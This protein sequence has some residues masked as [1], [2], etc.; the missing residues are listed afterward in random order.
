MVVI[1]KEELLQAANESLDQLQLTASPGSP[2]DDACLTRNASK[3]K[4]G[5]TLKLSEAVWI[6]PNGMPP[7]DLAPM[8]RA[9]TSPKIALIRSVEAMRKSIIFA[10]L[11]C[12]GAPEIQPLGDHQLQKLLSVLF[13]SLA[14]NADKAPSPEQSDA[15]LALGVL[16]KPHL[17]WAT[18]KA[19]KPDFAQGVSF[20]LR[21]RKPVEKLARQ[22][23][24]LDAWSA[25]AK[26]PQD[27][28]AYMDEDELLSEA[29]RALKV[30]IRSECAPDAAGKRK[31][32]KNCTCGLREEL[33]GQEAPV[34]KSACGN[35]ALGDAFRCASCPHRGKP[36]FEPGDELK[37]A[38]RS[39][40]S[41][42]VNEQAVLK[43]ANADGGLV[44]LSADAMVDDF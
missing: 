20:S 12:Q 43:L 29:D 37:L 27:T 21:S 13:P 3:L 1:S 33:E 17:A 11:E 41:A 42:P 4:K 35:C 40:E 23:P 26:A 38:S 18:A 19:R 9:L 7:A 34:V 28:V 15:L 16:L 5:G 8:V 24:P 32:C 39:D 30:P 44:Q 25:A 14:G 22:A 2:A 36:A 6:W 31:A 10:G